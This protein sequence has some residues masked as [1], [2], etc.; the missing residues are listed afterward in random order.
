MLPRD[1]LIRSLDPEL[2]HQLLECQH[3][4]VGG[5]ASWCL[6]LRAMPVLNQMLHQAFDDL[7]DRWEPVVPLGERHGE[8]CKI[9][10]WLVSRQYQAHR[11]GELLSVQ[12]PYLLIGVALPYQGGVLGL[13][14]GGETL[15]EESPG[16]CAPR[17]GVSSSKLA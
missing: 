4:L 3:R 8:L 11:V 12:R 14:L 5:V 16:F 2:L 13:P 7:I 1:P 17:W 15:L 9:N 6:P 10:C